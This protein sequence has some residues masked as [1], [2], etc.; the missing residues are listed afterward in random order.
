ML[1][2]PLSCLAQRTYVGSVVDKNTKEPLAYVTITL[3]KENIVTGTDT[4]GAFRLISRKIIRDDSIAFT[5]VGY[6]TVKIAASALVKS[7]VIMMQQDEVILN[8]VKIT[9]KEVKR[10]EIKLGSFSVYDPG[11][12]AS[13]IYYSNYVQAARKFI[14]PNNTSWLRSVRVARLIRF[15]IDDPVEGYYNYRNGR[16]RFRIRIYAV[17]PVT[18]GPGK[19]ICRDTIELQNNR[20]TFIE[21]D[22]TKNNIRITEKDF[23]IAV[24]WL[25]IP[26]NETISTWYVDFAEEVKGRKDGYAEYTL[27]YDPVL[28]GV[29]PRTKDKLPTTWLLEAHDGKWTSAVELQYNAD[30]AISAV[31]AVEK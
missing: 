28:Y 23:F 5:S 15:P 2:L 24:E 19:S 14:S 9:S 30:A 16:T 4:T 10:K 26:Y 7:R 31:I 13:P 3:I 27:E 8:E 6:I 22:L 17:D 1:L 29:K 18:G 11:F 25:M 12:G 20:N 21:I